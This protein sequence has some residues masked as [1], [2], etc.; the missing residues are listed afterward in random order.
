MIKEIIASEDIDLSSIKKEE[1]KMLNINIEIYLEE[2][3]IEYNS[4]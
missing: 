3:F 1:N 4:L 2:D